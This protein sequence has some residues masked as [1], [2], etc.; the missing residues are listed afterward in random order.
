MTE[1]TDGYRAALADIEVVMFNRG[2]EVTP[3]HLSMVLTDLRQDARQL[4]DELISRQ[5]RPGPDDIALLVF[6]RQPSA[7]QQP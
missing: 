1:W 2:W 7:G 3:E 6:R 5:P 4:R